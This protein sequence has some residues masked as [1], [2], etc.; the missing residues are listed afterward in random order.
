MGTLWLQ[1]NNNIGASVIFYGPAFCAAS[2]LAVGSNTVYAASTNLIGMIWAGQG[3]TYLQTVPG[4]WTNMDDSR[5]AI[6][7]GGGN[8]L[9]NSNSVTLA[10]IPAPNLATNYWPPTGPGYAGASPI[11]SWGGTN[12]TGGWIQQ[13]PMHVTGNV[14][15]TGFTGPLSGNATSANTAATATNAQRATASLGFTN[16]GLAHVLFVDSSGNDGNAVRGDISHPWLTL[17]N[18]EYSATNNDTIQLGVGVFDAFGNNLTNGATVVGSGQDLSAVTN[19]LSNANAQTHYI[20]VGANCE[21]DSLTLP[22]AVTDESGGT[23]FGDNL[24]GLILNNDAVGLLSHADCIWG[25]AFGAS[26]TANG[27]SFYGLNDFVA[28]VSN[29]V[30]N[31]CTFHGSDQYVTGSWPGLHLLPVNQGLTVIGGTFTLLS[32][33]TGITFIQGNSNSIVD[34]QLTAAAY[35]SASVPVHLYEPTFIYNQASGAS[36]IYPIYYAGVV[37]TNIFGLYYDVNLALGGVPVPTFV[38]K[39]NIYQPY[40]PYTQTFTG[41]GSGLTGITAQ[42]TN[43]TYASGIGTNTPSAGSFVTSPDGT[44]T[45]WTLNVN[46]NNASQLSSGTISPSL[47]PGSVVSTN[48]RFNWTFFPTTKTAYTNSLPPGTVPFSYSFV[49][50]TVTNSPATGYTTNSG[51]LDVYSVLNAPGAEV[52]SG[53]FTVALYFDRVTNMIVTFGQNPQTAGWCFMAPSG[54]YTANT[55]VLTN[56]DFQ[57]RVQQ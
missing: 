54:P 24:N 57:V 17:S 1:G 47:L 23:S 43:I 26:V 3:W 2:Q 12:G 40:N 20:A 49:M 38:V 51:C 45:A 34:F 31:S 11:T 35:A 4:T 52:D 9:W 8:L 6:G 37:A 13:G 56:W 10:L 14:T 22:W 39:T 21:L 29:S 41:N 15:A 18:A 36:P 46:T 32:T 55:I 50:I 28:G 53:P 25:E 30:I 44:S 42:G 19:S 33:N 16:Y 5:Y 7:Y 27:C 48:G